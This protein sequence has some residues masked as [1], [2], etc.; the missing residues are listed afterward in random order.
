MQDINLIGLFAKRYGFFCFVLCVP[1]LPY[2]TVVGE[3]SSNL[4]DL[5]PHLYPPPPPS[6]VLGYL[7]VSQPGKVF[8]IIGTD[9]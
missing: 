7:R 5:L 9:I 2:A 6:P 8:M 1:C 4:L 3:T